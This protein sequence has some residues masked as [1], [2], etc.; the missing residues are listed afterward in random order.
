MPDVK[1]PR[2]GSMA[3]YPRKRAKRSYPRIK[4]WPVSKEV[5]LLGFAGYK[6]GM[7]HAMVV[8][9]NP[10]SRT[11]GQV[12]MRPVTILD[13]PGLFV[14]GFKAYS[15]TPRGL[16]CL[17][18][19]LAEKKE[20]DLE[21][22]IKVKKTKSLE[23]Q[24]KKLE[25]KII[26]E[27]RLLAHTKPGFKKTPEIVEIALGGDGSKQLEYAKSLLGK[28]M[29]ASE[30]LKEGDFVD[31]FS[32]S[33]G[34]GTEGPVKRFG[35][36]VHHRRAQQM[37]RKVGGKGSKEPGKVR[38]TV[39]QG[40]QHGWQ[41]RMEY[42]K[43]IL[44]IVSNGAEVTPAGDFLRYGKIH[45][46]AVVIDGSVPG[47]SKRLIRLRSPI[48]PPKIKHGVNVRSISLD[49]KQGA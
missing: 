24:L 37:A 29:K 39:P 19:V 46:E 22:K 48:R 38:S 7:S 31:V 34:R 42:N 40:G 44:K 35:V 11:K 49:S 15:K 30:V 33:K 9:T 12:I 6:A 45:G 2:R 1:R 47:S 4:R 41:T 27:V 14:L 8:D 13:C 10:N 23:K 26:T 21:R 18:D 17:C 5:K 25:G 28:E 20:K 3:F 43:C 36:H 32:I 16:K